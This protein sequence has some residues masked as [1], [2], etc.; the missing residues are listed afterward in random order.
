MNRRI[1]ILL[2][3][4]LLTAG[5]SAGI[6]LLTGRP[7]LESIYLAIVTLTT[8]GSVDVAQGD[9]RAMVFVAAYL[10]CGLGTMTYG[11]FQ[12]G[13]LIVD[14]EPRRMLRRRRMQREIAELHDHYVICGLGRMGTAIAEHLSGHEQSF[15]VIDT[16][17]DRLDEI[18]RDRGWHRIQGDATEDDVLTDAGIERA[19]ALA[20]VLPTDADNV[21]VVLSARMLSPSVQI[22]ARAGDA[23]AAKKLQRAGATRVVNPFSSGAVKI[24]RFMLNPSVEDFLELA[25]GHGTELELADVHVTGESPYVG[26]Q[27]ADTDLAD[28]GVMVIGIRRADGERLLPPGGDAVIQSGDALLVFG[29][30]TAVNA[31]TA[32]QDAPVHERQ[33]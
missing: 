10:V 15:V 2:L 25:G 27:L 5:G 13:A 11:L 21:Y 24:A 9:P 26:V 33:S 8:V 16:D 31:V 12:L 32:Q 19:R 1:F 23:E 18:C 28:R 20:T 4:L 17:A 3:L 7:W 30:S 22:V 29:S 14:S 6:H